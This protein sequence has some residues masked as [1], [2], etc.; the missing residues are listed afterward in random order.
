VR[1]TISPFGTWAVR[2]T[3]V[4]GAVIVGGGGCNV[5]ANLAAAD[6]DE[7]DVGR[8][9]VC[10]GQTLRQLLNARAISDDCKHA[11]VSV[12]PSPVDNYSK[13]LV[14]LGTSEQSDGSLRVFLSG[15]DASGTAF[16]AEAYAAATVSVSDG[17]GG[18][19]AT[20]GS[21]EAT[22]VANAPGDVLSLGIVNDYSGSMSLDDL[23]VVERIET[24]LLT[25]LP[26]VCEVELTLF[27][28]EVEVT[29]P[30][31]T[32]CEAALPAVVRNTSFER[33]LTA[34]YDGMGTGLES[35]VS[36]T[37]PIRLLVVSTDGLENASQSHS[38]SEIVDTVAAE[39]VPVIMLG[40]L[41]ADVS[42]L[43]SL[44]GPRGLYFYTPLY[45]DLRER[46]L[47][48]LE[49]LANMVQID[50]PAAD[51]NRRPLRID[52]GDASVQLD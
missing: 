17:L 13:K 12:L 45:A 5:E 39:G 38:K 25:L 43:R 8:I 9:E 15:A 26:P 21:I 50:V 46:T 32:S 31:T 30:F 10:D 49:S 28:T 27:S 48:L 16:G 29:Q 1:Q 42:E 52:V 44:A 37:R 34:L 20:D 11:I 47:Q 51:A 19:V 6:L 40:A 2:F 18:F 24:D 7:E 35:L 36:R 14:V 33:D 3:A 22:L 4:F 41:F 23:G